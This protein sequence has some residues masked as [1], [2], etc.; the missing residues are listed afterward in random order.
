M[1]LDVDKILSTAEGIFHQIVSAPHLTDQIRI[2]LG[3][4]TIGRTDTEVNQDTEVS[5]KAECSRSKESSRSNG[6]DQRVFAPEADEVMYQ[7]GLDMNF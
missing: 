6:S 1:R 7:I 5:P 2:I 4:P 3:L